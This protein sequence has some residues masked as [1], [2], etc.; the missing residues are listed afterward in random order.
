MTTPI[1]VDTRWDGQHGIGRYARE[2]TS[3]LTVP[4][5]PLG[6]GGAPSSPTGAVAKVPTGL[7]Y[8]PGYNAFLRAERQVL[9]IHDLIHLQTPWPGRAKY[10]AYY[11]AVVKPV[12]KR[13]GVVIT[14][15]ETSR[16][17]IADWLG[18]PSV[19][20]VNA[21]LGASP[22]FHVDAER[23]A[24]THPY[25]MYVGN[26]REHKNLRVV[27]NA[28]QL[29]REARL[30]ALIPAAEHAHAQKLFAER[31]ISDRVRLL[32]ALRD[33]DLA[34]QYR[35]ATAT[36]MPSRLEGFGLPPLESIMTGTPVIFWRG[37]EAI[38]ETVGAR[39]WVVDRVADTEEWAQTIRV[40]LS[41][42]RRVVPPTRA[43]DW[44]A[45]ATAVDG[46][47]RSLDPSGPASTR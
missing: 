47:L 38:A 17:A 36:I 43:Y 44:G 20:I 24:A 6:M 33:D 45:T 22:A 30:H 21:G 8:S 3:R 14:V 35:G 2:V 12:V 27:L 7:V 15:S 28:L 31:N 13:A 37:C 32:P 42:S 18:D 25:L 46:V 16:R 40:A 23:T 4:W 34:A 11:N 29:V 9:T 1:W 41:S 19:D 26:L 10:L 5:R 39:G